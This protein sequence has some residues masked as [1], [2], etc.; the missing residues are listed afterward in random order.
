[1]S[2]SPTV[3]VLDAHPACL[4]LKTD[5]RT[6]SG[7]AKNL[8]S[9]PV[10]TTMVGAVMHYCR[11]FGDLGHLPPL[12]SVIAAGN[13]PIQLV[14]WNSKDDR[15]EQLAKGLE[16]YE[17]QAIDEANRM[18]LAFNEA[19]RLMVGHADAIGMP[20]RG[21]IVLVTMSKA[22]DELAF[23]HRSDFDSN[24]TDLRITAYAAAKQQPQRVALDVDV[25]RIVPSTI[26]SSPL[27]SDTHRA[28]LCES[29]SISV[30]HVS[31]GPKD[32]EAAMTQL[33]VRTNA[34]S[35]V[36]LQMGA[37]AVTLLYS[38]SGKHLR[39]APDASSGADRYLTRQWTATKL[40]QPETAAMRLETCSCAHPACLVDVCSKQAKHIIDSNQQD[41]LWRIQG[42][43]A[44]AMI[45]ALSKGTMR[46]FCVDPAMEHALSDALLETAV[47][48]E[49]DLAFQ[50][51][52]S[53]IEER[54]LQMFLNEVVRPCTRDRVLPVHTDEE[55][56]LTRIVPQQFMPNTLKEHVWT[57]N[58]M[59]RLTKWQSCIR[60]GFA[61]APEDSLAEFRP[62][63][64]DA[65][66]SSLFCGIETIP[67]P[68]DEQ[69][70]NLRQA[71]IQASIPSV[72]DTKSFIEQI[73]S[74]CL[75]TNDTKGKKGKMQVTSELVPRV[76]AILYF[77]SLR[78]RD[79]SE[80]HYMLCEH[81][82][83][84]LT[85]K[86]PAQ[87]LRKRAHDASAHDGGGARA[88]NAVDMAWDQT[89]QL[90]SMTYR[91][92]QELNA[93]TDA[94]SEVGINPNFR[95]RRQAPVASSAIV[96]NAYL[97]FQ[98]PTWAEIKE[99]AAANA[100]NTS[101]YALL[102]QTH[103]VD[104]SPHEFEGRRPKTAD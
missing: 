50:N 44:D 6:A 11:I 96:T 81:I 45:L 2:L 54:K 30:Y 42:D 43:A 74:T 75:H 100:A 25:L 99:R 22:A 82:Y 70:A 28:K 24:P 71:M 32:L 35:E 65:S 40:K 64:V 79:E 68:F 58:T 73:I 80:R 72:P 3:F 61:C 5:Q 66:S 21:R 78:F 27:P 36:H 92:K 87:L 19:V 15:Q 8:P 84:C 14:D 38:L 49:E 41:Q 83:N 93:G 89:K 23:A 67:P 97:T 88:P 85:S 31:N 69:L 95:G 37:N 16:G 34:V 57:T 33:I 62:P 4:D 104:I 10:W 103:S 9:Y 91:E 76:K 7:A 56:G 55:N 52:R 94:S 86:N 47:K 63:V 48:K 77:V 98:Q 59:K 17:L 101:P 29:A 39:T 60:D 90:E 12:I 102:Q 13:T 46:I 53:V 26:V 51:V 1:M 20:C 18:N